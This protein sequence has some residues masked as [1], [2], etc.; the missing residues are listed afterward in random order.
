M[1]SISLGVQKRVDI[2]RTTVANQLK[3]R[4]VDVELKTDNA[5]DKYKSVQGQ[6]QVCGDFE[7]VQ[8]V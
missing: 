7:L 2:Y 6:L 5:R 1:V 4:L 8:D 3:S